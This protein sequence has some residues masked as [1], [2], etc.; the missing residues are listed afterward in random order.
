MS[1]KFDGMTSTVEKRLLIVRKSIFIANMC[2]E[3]FEQ[4]N[5][6]IGGRLLK[7]YLGVSYIYGT[8]SIKECMHQAVRVSV[9]MDLTK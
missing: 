3:E 1:F 5:I 7:E 8:S 6:S 2:E 4:K 9:G